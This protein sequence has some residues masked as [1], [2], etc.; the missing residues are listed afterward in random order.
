MTKNNKTS[1]DPKGVGG[2]LYRDNLVQVKNIGK[3]GVQKKSDSR[4][5]ELLIDGNIAIRRMDNPTFFT[6]HYHPIS[7]R[8]MIMSS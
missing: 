2:K 4:S 6:R 1:E 7:T 3:E 5:K 8:D